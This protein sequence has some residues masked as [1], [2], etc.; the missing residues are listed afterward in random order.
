MMVRAAG[1]NHNIVHLK[2]KYPKDRFSIH[3]LTNLEFMC[4]LVIYPKKYNFNQNEKIV[5]LAQFNHIIK[6]MGKNL[7]TFDFY[8]AR[9]TYEVTKAMEDPPDLIW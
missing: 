8:L 9:L 6:V 7:D 1:H 2:R 5:L 4:G 3:R